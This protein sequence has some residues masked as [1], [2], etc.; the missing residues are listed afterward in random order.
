MEITDFPELADESYKWL[1]DNA[2]GRDVKAR[3]S[4]IHMTELI[5]CLTAGYWNKIMP[6]PATREQALLMAL[7]IGF[8]KSLIP[9]EERALPG[10]CEG[11][12]YSPD[13][14]YKGEMP[15]ELKTTRMS[16]KKT[17]T[18]DYPV[19]WIQQIMGYCYA[20]KKLEYGLSVVHMM[21]GYQP[22]FPVILAVRFNFNQQE[23][24]DNWNY[25]MWRKNVYIQGFADMQPPTP[26]KWCQDWECKYCRYATSA[27]HCNIKEAK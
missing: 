27:I 13:F 19:T 16:T 6:L 14:W 2:A 22:P 7:G 4:G 12:E 25:L 9:V 20:E 17:Y 24:I 23:L 11:V 3:T 8:E 15:A 26:T 5:Y 10:T 1:I 21:G 18:R